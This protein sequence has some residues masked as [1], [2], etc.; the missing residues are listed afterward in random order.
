MNALCG[1][2][3]SWSHCIS[4]F[5]QPEA[6]HSD[7]KY[8]SHDLNYN[9]FSIIRDEPSF[10]PRPSAM[11]L[12]N[13]PETFG[14]ERASKKRRGLGWSSFSSQKRLLPSNS[15]LPRRPR[16][17][18]PSD[19]RH[20]YSDSF[21]FP[22]GTLS[23]PKLQSAPF[24]PLQL[25]LNISDTQ[26]S[27]ILPRLNYTSRPVTPPPRIYIIP[28]PV[29]PGSP[30]MSHQ[31]SHS[32]Q[33]F[34]IPR[35]PVNGSAVSSRSNTPTPQRLQPVRTRGLSPSP[36]TPIMEDLVERVANAMLERD[37]LQ[38]QIDDIV[39]KQYT[40]TS[41]SP[42]STSHGQPGLGLD[43][44]AKSLQQHNQMSMAEM[45]PMPE[46]LALPPNAPSF[47]ERLS[48]DHVQSTSSIA[49]PAAPTRTVYEANSSRKITGRAPP[50]P[51]PL[52]LRPPLRKKK[53]FSRVSS[54]LFPAAGGA[55]HRREMSLD[56][57]T[58]APRPVTGGQGFYQVARPEEANLRSSFDTESTVSDWTVEEQTILTSLS[59]SNLTTPRALATPSSK[60]HP[61][62]LQEPIHFQHRQSVGIAF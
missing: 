1:I 54:W 38:D 59:P 34:S 18:P 14:E 20:V 24:H 60:G 33:S 6:P 56:S 5:C 58:N 8:Q 29:D 13:T 45:E 61:F 25:N 15:S 26:L 35:R 16:I 30:A 43:R 47:S 31:R 55:G 3:S 36:P 19:F 2:V 53:S 23:Q 46:I 28:S 48:S 22:E 50:P 39:E 7:E 32:A 10:M 57:I 12:R 11:S 40:Y 9:S 62:G 41:S 4:Q 42:S 21:H 37:R 27:P 44:D 17:S 52:R 49:Q 51:L